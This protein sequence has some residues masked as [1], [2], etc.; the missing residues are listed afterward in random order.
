MASMADLRAQAKE[1]GINSFG[2]TAEALQAEIQEAS[3]GAFAEV[4]EDVP[5]TPAKKP[6]AKAQAVD[7]AAVYAVLSQEI[8]DKFAALQQQVATVKPVTPEAVIVK[9]HKTDSA[10]IAQMEKVPITIPGGYVGAPK[11][12]S[13]CV[14]GHRISIKTGVENVMVPVAHYENLMR[15]RKIKQANMDRN[16][17]REKAA[18]DAGL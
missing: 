15:S 18:L 16:K 5:E 4:T 8:N 7:P 11:R 12:V 1:L 9:A 6:A 13:S 17:K 3:G 10:T 14:N 2:K